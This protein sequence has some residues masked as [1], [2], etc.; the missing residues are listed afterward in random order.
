MKRQGFFVSF[1][2]ILMVV[3]GGSVIYFGHYAQRDELISDIDER[4]PVGLFVMGAIMAVSGFLGFIGA[5]CDSKMLLAI[6]AFVTLFVWVAVLALGVGLLL[7][8]MNDG[9]K[10]ERAC[11]IDETTG[12]LQEKLPKRLQTTYDKLWEALT[13]CRTKLPDANSLQECGDF[14]TDANGHQVWG[15]NFQALYQLAEK[16]YHCAGFCLDGAPVFGYPNEDG[17]EVNRA[18]RE[19][20]RRACYHQLAERFAAHGALLTGLLLGF[21]IP[22]LL[23]MLAAWWMVCLPPPRKMKGYIHQPD[24]DEGEEMSDRPTMY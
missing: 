10:I 8:V 22:L 9:Y 23:S 17:V 6:F 7:L 13:I 12:E 11:A 24:E 19:V 18:N 1:G 14:S 5:V 16:K 3:L 15:I 21:S 20:P 4:I 2:G